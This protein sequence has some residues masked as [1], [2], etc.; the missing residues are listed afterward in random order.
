L[1]EGLAIAPGDA[2]QQLRFIDCCGWGFH[3]VQFQF[4]KRLPSVSGAD[5][6]IYAVGCIAFGGGLTRFVKEG[7]NGP[8]SGM[9]GN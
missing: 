3:G 9:Q 6:S 5:R 1:G 7:T 2:L 4:H 8:D